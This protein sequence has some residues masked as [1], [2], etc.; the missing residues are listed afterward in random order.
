MELIRLGGPAHGVVTKTVH[1]TLL[2]VMGVQ[3]WVVGWLGGGGGPGDGW[4]G[5]V[6]GQGWL[7]RWWWGCRGRLVEVV[8]V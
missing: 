3:G 8:G 4:I 2:G 1:K 7:G 6:G 5:V